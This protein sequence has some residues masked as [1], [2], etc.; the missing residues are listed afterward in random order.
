MKKK[1]LVFINDS[2][3]TSFDSAKFSLRNKKNIFWIVGG[4]PKKG[5]KLY[6]G[7]LT[8]NIIKTYIIGKNMKFFQRQLK[9]KIEFKLCKNLKKA[10]RDIFQ[11]IKK[12]EKDKKITILFSPAAA[13][14]DQYDNFENRGNEFKRLSRLY[15][16]KFK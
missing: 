10:I 3:A 7:N 9:G 16:K 4:L 11:D 15:A 13:S 6:L 14:Y 8:K 5:D 1:N 2:K 12:I